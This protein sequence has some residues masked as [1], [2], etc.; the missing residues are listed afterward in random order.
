MSGFKQVYR[1]KVIFPAEY[2]ASE[3]G[4]RVNFVLFQ[5]W[6]VYNPVTKQNEDFKLNCSFTPKDE[7]DITAFILCRVHSKKT[8]ELG[9]L[10]G[11]SYTTV[12][13]TVEGDEHKVFATREDGT[14]GTAIYKSLQFC[15]V[16]IEEP[17]LT[18]LAREHLKKIDD[19]GSET[20]VE[21]NQPEEPPQ[22]VQQRVG[23][24]GRFKV[25]DTQ[26]VDGVKYRFIGGDEDDL[27]NWPE[28]KPEVVKQPVVT[29]NVSPR[30]S[31]L[32]NLIKGPKTLAPPVAA[33]EEEEP[34]VHPLERNRAGH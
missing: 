11:K 9:G 22:V 34:Y 5:E 15:R 4:N 20:V 26:E 14:V 2:V 16:T 28:V 13:V 25:G 17:E 32:E 1:G 24:V 12:R 3:K 19:Y 30:N 8:P 21:N 33:P 10:M 18:K 29:K 7:K 27:D 23:K 6:S 31:S